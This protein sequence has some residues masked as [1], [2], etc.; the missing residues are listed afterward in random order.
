LRANR[1]QFEDARRAKKATAASGGGGGP[2]SC[3]LEVMQLREKRD[4][5]RVRLQELSS[6]SGQQRDQADQVHT[7]ELRRLRQDVENLHDEKEALRQKLQDADRTRQE[8]QENF[9]YVKN[10]LD[11]VQVKQAQ[12]SAGNSPE[13]KE[14]QRYT[15]A[16]Q[17]IA[18]ERSR[19]NMRM[20]ALQKEIEKEKGYHE[21]SLDRVMTSN[22]KLLE[23]KNRAEKD[24]QRLSQL[25][26]DSVQ[27]VQQEDKG[28]EASDNR[29]TDAAPVADAGDRATINKLR[30]EIAQ[31]DESL[32]K[33]ESE[34][35]SLKSRIRKLAVA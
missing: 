10:Q 12:T 7:H 16:I 33:K 2:N 30:A 29:D 15:E 4:M 27:N 8:L 23:E 18:E 11:K 34:N 32:Q 3:T 5:L 21:S 9:L 6:S 25:Y 35:E 1:K 20:E 17:A 24:V 28:E 14:A 22:G 26:A 19:L 13:E 31:V